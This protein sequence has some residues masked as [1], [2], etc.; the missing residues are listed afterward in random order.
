MASIFE[1]EA[2]EQFRKFLHHLRA[3]VA[4]DHSEG[5]DDAP[6]ITCEAWIDFVQQ[7]LP[8]KGV[9]Y[10]KAVE[11]LTSH[12]A[13]V[14][15]ACSYRDAAAV[16]LSDSTNVALKLRFVDFEEEK[17]DTFWKIVEE[18]NRNAHVGTGKQMP[19]V[20]SREDIQKVFE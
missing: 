15:H 11:R 16:S 4:T 5:E 1:E 17:G 18:L 7:P 20:P 8:A 3:L 19:T 9:K 12:P 6:E 14:L 10:A 2:R 13:C